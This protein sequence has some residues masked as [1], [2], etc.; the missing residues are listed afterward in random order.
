MKIVYIRTNG[1]DMVIAIDGPC[2]WYRTE[3]EEFPV[4]PS[5]KEAERFLNGIED[6]SGWENNLTAKALLDDIEK[7]NNSIVAEIETEL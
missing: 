1:Y 7:H 3:T 4:H 5:K 6:I 2:A